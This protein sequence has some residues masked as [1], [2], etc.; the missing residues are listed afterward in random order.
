MTVSYTGQ[1]ASVRFGGFARLLLCWKGSI[2]KLVY[3]ELLVFLTLYYLISLTY[4]YG[5]G[6]VGRKTFEDVVP[7]FE[8]F[9]NLIPL[10]FVVG[11]YVSVVVA[12]W[13]NQYMTVP[14]PD[15]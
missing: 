1:V 2:Y 6:T 12:R 5:L 4:R 14:W 8:K 15:A 3:R 9:S 13:W 11:F 7:R 10:T